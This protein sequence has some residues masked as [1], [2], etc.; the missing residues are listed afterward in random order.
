[1][2]IVEFGG[3][4][5]NQLFQLSMAKYLQ[6]RFHEDIVCDVT[7]FTHDSREY[8]EFELNA[9]K[10]PDDWAI[11]QGD[12]SK[13]EVYGLRYYVWMAIT[14]I[15][16]KTYKLLEKINLRRWYGKF[17]QNVINLFGIYCVMNYYEDYY[18]PKKSLWRKKIV[19][20]NW[21]WPEMVEDNQKWIIDNVYVNTAI[22]ESNQHYLEQIKGTN[23][24]A[25]HIRRGD[26][27]TLG[28]VVCS[29]N[30]YAMCIKKMC[31]MVDN[32]VFYIFSDDIDWCKSNLRVD[33]NLVFVDNGNT[34][35]DDFRLMY[36]CNHFIM[37]SSTFSWWASFL[38]KCPE[39]IIITPLH[40]NVHQDAIN[41]LIRQTMIAVENRNV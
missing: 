1:M 18:V 7:Q 25:V 27:V 22:S 5:G 11:I 4:L 20:G 34:T 15:Y 19:L 41:P 28:L 12:K 2:F 13:V 30:Y 14:F 6:E 38:G 32:P 17:Y 31:E 10:L 26:Y 37:S 16:Q 23:S 39:K 3:G 24:V 29:V 40:W 9:F 35:T 33:A 8:R 36:S 21:L